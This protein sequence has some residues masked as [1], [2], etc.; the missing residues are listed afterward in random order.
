MQR[1]RSSL[2]NGT[3]MDLDEAIRLT[4][5]ALPFAFAVA[6]KQC[7]IALEELGRPQ[8]LPVQ[9]DERGVKTG[10]WSNQ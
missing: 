10:S 7:S 8:N 5:G 4:L 9:F 3:D 2:Q 6:P 1:A